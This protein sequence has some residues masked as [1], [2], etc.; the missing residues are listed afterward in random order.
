MPHI[1]PISLEAGICR[2]S[3]PSGIRGEVCIAMCILLI[4]D[5]DPYIAKHNMYTLTFTTYTL[6]P[7]CKFGASGECL[8]DWM[9]A[10]KFTQ[11]CYNKHHRL[12]RK[13]YG[14]QSIHNSIFFE[15]KKLNK[16]L[17]E[18]HFVASTDNS[19]IQK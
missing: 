1:I 3:S 17:K 19:F 7:L 18:Q 9:L 10:V 16:N 14:K 13:L 6:T 12:T 15:K 11:V 8:S 5:N 2:K 4:I